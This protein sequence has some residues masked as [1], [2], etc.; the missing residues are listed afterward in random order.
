MFTR[1]DGKPEFTE[2]WNLTVMM[3]DYGHVTHNII[4]EEE[5]SSS[6]PPGYVHNIQF[7]YNI[8]QIVMK[9][10]FFVESTL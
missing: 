9:L 6:S 7:L 5:A 10:T 8:M 4:I 1:Q 3:E 2:M